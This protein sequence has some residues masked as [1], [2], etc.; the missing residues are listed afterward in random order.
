MNNNLVSV[1]VSTKNSEKY[2]ERCLG[3]VRKQ[4]YKNWELIVVDNYSTDKTVEIAKKY[5]KTVF[6]YG[7]ER[8]S[9]YNFAVKKAKGMYIYRIDSDFL[10]E[11]DVIREC[12]GKIISDD[13]DGI[14]VHNISDPKVSFW[15]KVRKLERDCYR[16]DNS[17]VAVRFMKKKVFES[18]GGF[19]E[20]MYA[21]EDYDLHNRFV[22][23]GYKWGRIRAKEIHLGEIK[24]LREVMF[25]SFFYGK[26]LIYYL[27]KYPNIGKKQMTPIRP[28]F[29]R[30]WKDMMKH[31]ILFVGLLVMNVVK[32]GFGGLGYVFAKY[33]IIKQKKV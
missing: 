30:H 5:T 7:P 29:I 22:S 20:R 11:P 27:D 16:D 6:L 17:I 33:K 1:V 14:A 21:G 13:L 4:T 15:S 28:A 24:S 10:L 9:Q 8:S 3:S 32:F 18:I 19:D 12:V 23:K 25:K 26:N 31:P 2:L